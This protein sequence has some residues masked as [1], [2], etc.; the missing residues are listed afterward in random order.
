M[1]AP[2]TSPA[3][4]PGGSPGLTDTSRSPYVKMHSIGLNEVT[5]NQGFW[6][7]RFAVVRDHMLPHMWE[8]MEG[9]HHSHFVENFRIAAGLS[10]GKHRGPQWNDGDLYKWMEGAAAVYALTGD[11]RI[12]RTL[13]EL[14][15]LIGRVQRPDG[16]IH[17]PTLIAQRYGRD[18]KPLEDRANFE[19]YN[20][21]HLMTAACVHY[22]ATGKTNFL[23]IAKKTAGFLC[24]FFR[25][26]TP[27]KARHTI[28]P[29]H[30]MG[31]IEL[32]RTTRDPKYLELGKRF[33]EMRD[34][35]EEGGDDNQDRIPF[36]QQR[37]AVG[38]AVRANYLYAGVADVYAETGDESLLETL[39]ALWENV[40]TKKMYVNGA[41]G[42]LYDGASPDGS[43]DQKSIT[44]V[45]Q[46]YGRNY[47]LPQ[48]TAHNETCANIGNVLWNWRM[49]QIT[50]EARFADVMELAL[51]SSVLAGASLDG[52]RFFYTNTLRQLDEL[53]TVLRWPKSRSEWISCY[54]CPPNLLRTVA[55]VNNYVYGRSPEGIWV[56]LYG[57][58]TLTSTLLDG[59]PVRLVQ[60]TA[61]PWEGSV[62]ILVDVPA[63]T[64]FSLFLRIPGWARSASIRVNGQAWQG[65]V[66]PGTYAEVRRR[67]SPG[68][69]LLL[70]IPLEVRLLVAHPLVEEASGQVAVQRG[71]IV[72]CLESVD[73]PEGVRVLDVIL[74]RNARL[75]PRFDPGLLGGVTVLEG[76][77]F[78][79]AS[80]DWRGKLYQEVM[81]V[82][83]QEID[84]RLIPYYA[85]DN[86]GKSEMT[87][88]IRHEA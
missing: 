26:L 16:Y 41:C 71:P 70:E 68:D 61:Y 22:R 36:R 69:R 38:H 80:P 65:E 14:I 28:C 73:L 3:P 67:W 85:W 25:E 45:H 24:D 50:G 13:D 34:L 54:C 75:V 2:T 9:T 81:D 30:Y 8:I 55:E 4:V 1:S 40:V 5:W 82:P 20:M 18:V 52:R 19:M 59:T 21:G 87:V 83:A 66:K 48:T 78:A 53:P 84:V 42:A 33:I 12:D 43:P 60:G 86:R 58:C 62:E 7:E 44:R 76:R 63:G 31:I 17:T 23:E 56:N 6:G 74:P 11:P 39:E 29:S 10:E 72:Y 51:Y 57:A 46:A 88:W 49:L 15:A 27:E 79:K 32:Y 37:E 35:I 64:E 77:A 47:Q